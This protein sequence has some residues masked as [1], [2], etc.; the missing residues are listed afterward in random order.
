M[1]KDW[2][3][4]SLFITFEFSMEQQKE[5]FKEWFN[6]PY[7]HILY[8]DRD[9]KEA[10][11]FLTNLVNQFNPKPESNFLDL[12]CGAGRH[13]IFLNQLGFSVT[14]IDLSRHSIS[15]AKAFENPTLHFEV[16]D[17]RTFSLN[18]SFDFVLNLF[19]SFGYFDCMNTNKLVLNQ[20]KLALKPDGYFIIDF[21]NADKILKELV[22]HE[23]KMRHG[24][25]FD[26][27]KTYID[28]IIVKDIW[29]SDQGKSFHYQEKV[30]AL[31]LA[32]FESLL[33]ACQLKITQTFGDYALH[34]F[35]VNTSNRLILITQL[36][37]A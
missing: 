26:I 5:W 8:G 17:L 7:Y 19:T 12:A 6:S 2:F 29:F 25:A 10:E 15:L 24:I 4:P 18:E 3:E 31:T 30:Q 1:V 33:A 22:P 37:H 23:V 28:G 34:S 14:G 32:D 27:H 13:S 21:M 36:N 16:G 20:V 9:Q 35:D 11:F